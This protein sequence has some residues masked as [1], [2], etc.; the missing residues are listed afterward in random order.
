MEHRILL[1]PLAQCG[2]HNAHADR[3]GGDIRNGGFHHG[4]S[5]TAAEL[6]AGK[7][8][9]QLRQ[10]RRLI[11]A[12]LLLEVGGPPLIPAT[13]FCGGE[14]VEELLEC[15]GDLRRFM[16]ELLELWGAPDDFW[17]CELSGHRCSASRDVPVGTPVPC[18]TVSG[19]ETLHLVFQNVKLGGCSVMCPVRGDAV[20]WLAPSRRTD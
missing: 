14:L 11:W 19:A 18:G 13:F 9:E 8:R 12:V 4:D 7:G 5:T 17:S 1:Q 6:F 15:R 3:H 20:R 2:G 16:D 10:E